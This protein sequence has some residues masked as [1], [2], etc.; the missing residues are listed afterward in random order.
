MVAEI[1]DTGN[2]RSTAPEPLDDVLLRIRDLDALLELI[3]DCVPEHRASGTE[4][5]VRTC[6]YARLGPSSFGARAALTASGL[7]ST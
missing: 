4:S 1:V 3:C 7:G 2:G 5:R 6:R